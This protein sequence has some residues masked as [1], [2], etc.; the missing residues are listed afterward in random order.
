[1]QKWLKVQLFKIFIIIF[2][3]YLATA[4]SSNL[5]AQ[6][7]QIQMGTV[8]NRYDANGDSPQSISYPI[9]E[10]IINAQYFTIFFGGD[11]FLSDLMTDIIRVK[12]INYPLSKIKNIINSSDISFANLE[13][14]FTTNKI[15]F[16]NKQYLYKSNPEYIKILTNT[17]F[18]VLNIA[19]DS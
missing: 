4:Q 3:F 14:P 5:Y 15:P 7:I 17:G 11:I 10:K 16:I 19:S 13:A 1:M 8:P 12:G 18:D 6:P 9:P 2:I